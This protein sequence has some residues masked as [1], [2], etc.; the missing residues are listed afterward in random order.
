MKVI[1]QCDKDRTGTSVHFLPDPKIFEET[2]VYDY[3]ILKNRLREL[4]FLNKGLRITLYDDRE[5]DKKEK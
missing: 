1:D 3:D 4:A 5:V 2:T